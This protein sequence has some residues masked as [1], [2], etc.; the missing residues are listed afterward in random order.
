MRFEDDFFDE[1]D[2][3][4]KEEMRRIRK[5]ITEITRIRV[6]DLKE[7]ERRGEPIVFGFSY[8]WH[9]GM[10]KPEIKFFGN[11]KPQQPFGVKVDDAI[12]PV[13][14]IID[15]GDHY[16][17]IIELAGAKKDDVNIEMKDRML[18]V[19]ANTK[20]KKYKHSIP[21]PPDASTSEV[22]AKLNNG[23]LIVTLNKKVNGSSMKIKIEE[24]D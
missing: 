15:K 17:I 9:S 10:E 2:R 3:L 24:E 13:Y 12:T 23:I 11:V 14:D 20:Y 21:L 8:R 6:N 19:S 18:Y 1:I 5:L 22:K 7:L 16:E 4:F